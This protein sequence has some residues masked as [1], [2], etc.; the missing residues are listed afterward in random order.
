MII[1]NNYQGIM[2]LFSNKNSLFA[3]TQS[4]NSNKN[5]KAIEDLLS[6][7]RKNS[8]GVSGMR[9]TGRTDWK[10]IINISDEMKQHVYDDVKKEFYKYGGMS[11]SDTD[12][13][14]YYDKIHDYVK[15]LKA[16]DRSPATWT[17]SQLHLDIAH[18][19]NSAVKEKMP[20]WT[21]G[22]QIPSNVL[23]EIFADDK[24]FNNCVN[25]LFNKKGFDT[26][27]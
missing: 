22:Q 25:N 20:G 15:T 21:S 16:D 14:A 11:G 18:K 23:D 27:I 6:G 1:G 2:R 5:K 4:K 24:L 13:N 7:R 19:V 9:I 12:M 3:D 17:L 8:Y 26:V 10:K